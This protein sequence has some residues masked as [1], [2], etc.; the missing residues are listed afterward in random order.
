[1]FCLMNEIDF[2]IAGVPKAGTTWLTWNLYEGEDFEWTDKDQGEYE[3]IK[4]G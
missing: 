3:K 4:N 1:M 2:I